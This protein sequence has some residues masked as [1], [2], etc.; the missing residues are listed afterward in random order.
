LASKKLIISAFLLISM[1]LGLC[2]PVEAQSDT[3]YVESN[4]SRIIEV[5]VSTEFTIEIWIRDLSTQAKQMWFTIE[6]DPD[7]MEIVGG[8]T[9][10]PSGWG[11]STSSTTPGEITYSAS[12]EP[13]QGDRSWYS[14]TFHCT[15]PGNTPINV[16]SAHYKDPG[17]GDNTL[18]VLKASVNQIAPLPVGGLVTP[19]NKLVMLTPYI[20][21]AGLIITVSTVYVIKK[22]KD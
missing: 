20:A 7:S 8:T 12:G 22:R 3:L 18:S 15:A 14:I 9:T 6:Y 21:L 17:D 16:R 13:F 4:G 19:T 5:N 10:P 2:L 11:A 1:V